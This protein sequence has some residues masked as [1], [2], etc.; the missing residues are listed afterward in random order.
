MCAPSWVTGS[1]TLVGV[2]PGRLPGA[3]KSGKC[4]R[5]SEVGEEHNR[6]GAQTV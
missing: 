3:G 2:S 1:L 6:W 4:E 5:S